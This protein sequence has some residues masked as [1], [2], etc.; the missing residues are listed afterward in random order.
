MEALHRFLWGLTADWTTL[1]GLFLTL[2]LQVLPLR[3]LPRACLDLLVMLRQRQ[4]GP[5]EISSRAAHMA[6]LGGILG[7]G[8]LTGMA[9]TLSAGGAGVVP[10][11]W[12]VGLLGMATKQ[13]E[14]FLAVRFREPGPR[15]VYV[16]GP[17][18]VIRAA[19]GR[20][21]EWLAV[22]AAALGSL[23]VFGAGNSVQA[24]QLTAGLNQLTGQPPLLLAMLAAALI[25]WLLHGGLPRIGRLSA[26]LV[27]LMLLGYLSL[28]VAGLAQHGPAL[29]AALRRMLSEA[30]SPRAL[31]GG[32]LALT[33]RTAVLMSVF[34]TESGMG[35]TSIAHAAASPADPGF[36]GRLA[37]I[38]NVI[39][40][41]VCTATALLL[42]VS[43]VLETGGAHG[44]DALNDSG[45]I[46][47]LQLAWSRCA[48]GGDWIVS[49]WLVLFAFTTLLSFGYY[50]E[51][52]FCGLVGSRGRLPFRVLWLLATVI[53]ARPVFPEIWGFS[54]VLEALMVLPNLLLLLLLSNSFFHAVVGRA[55]L[56][57]PARA[58]GR[59]P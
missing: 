27:P 46:R 24:R 40:L 50:G 12:V 38:G 11:M 31:A 29:G 28:T 36:Q 45:A 35:T 43:G 52:F 32:G 41:L 22:L 51:R 37:G 48:P 6:S 20:R 8:H 17:V 53:A 21:W 7:V 1:V 9:I 14:T 23:G 56:T 2:G 47:L 18:E 30:F 39:S 10:W 3:Q 55:P 26:L 4:A 19:R 15:G 42:L 33:V 5:G 16:G 44:L 34:T 13:A 58:A 25:A 57:M 59:D 49:V 54:Q